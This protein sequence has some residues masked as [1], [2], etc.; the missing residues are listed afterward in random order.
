MNDHFHFSIPHHNHNPQSPLSMLSLKSL[1]PSTTPCH[2]NHHHHHHHYN[3]YQPV[4]CDGLIVLCLPGETIAEIF[5]LTHEEFL[6]RWINY[7]LEKVSMVMMVMAMVMVMETPTQS[8]L[9][10]L[11][12]WSS[13]NF[14]LVAID[15]QETSQA[16]SRTPKSTRSCSTRC[17]CSYLTL[18]T[19]FIPNTEYWWST[20][21]WCWICWCWCWWCLFSDRSGWSLCWQVCHG[22]ET[23]GGS[24]WG[25]N[26]QN[27]DDD[28]DDNDGDG[29][30]N[31]NDD[32]HGNEDDHDHERMKMTII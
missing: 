20:R 18:V 23:L 8:W 13:L 25:R 29:G 22:E 17:W 3:N 15:V 16:T 1:F 10:W 26:Q 11:F 24:G 4:F 5:K 14:R 32:E 21:C 28:D 6:L 19:Q 30:G 31:D 9:D 7:H 2:H 12:W 27:Y